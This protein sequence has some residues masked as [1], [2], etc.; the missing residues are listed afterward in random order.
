MPIV[1]LGLMSLMLFRATNAVHLSIGKVNFSFS[2]RKVMDLSSTAITVAGK[3]N[4]LAA[5]SAV[6]GFW[7]GGGAG[8]AATGLEFAGPLLSKKIP[9]PIR[10]SRMVAAAKIKT[11]RF[12]FSEG[13]D[14][15][16]GVSLSGE[17][18]G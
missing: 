12:M 13:L 3:A 16:F 8:A 17:M 5:S 15:P 1:E 7:A 4:D 9:L 6:G 14:Y 2:R 18:V 10:R 11:E